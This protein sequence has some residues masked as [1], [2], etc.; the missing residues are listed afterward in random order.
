MA[1]STFCEDWDEIGSIEP[2][3]AILV[4]ETT[5]LAGCQWVNSCRG[6]P[7]WGNRRPIHKRRKSFLKYI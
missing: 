5:K 1:E 2:K 6:A 4:L 7:P 3:K